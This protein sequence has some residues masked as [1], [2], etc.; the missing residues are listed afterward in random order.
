MNL[1][2]EIIIFLIATNLAIN[3]IILIKKKTDK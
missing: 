1:L 3:T 2:L